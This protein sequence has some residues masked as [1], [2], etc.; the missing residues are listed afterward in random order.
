MSH[1]FSRFVLIS[2]IF[3]ATVIPAGAQTPAP[4]AATPA[5]AAPAPL[6]AGFQDLSLIH[7]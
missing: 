6:Q 4:P 1:L 2:A 5:A 7:I 3:A